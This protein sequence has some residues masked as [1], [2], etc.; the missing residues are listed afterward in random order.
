M[1]GSLRLIGMTETAP[2][3][4]LEHGGGFVVE[5][6]DQLKQYFQDQ[7]QEELAAF[8]AEPVVGSR[9]GR[10]FRAVSWYTPLQGSAV[11]LPEAKGEER[12][13]AIAHLRRMLVALEPHLDHPQAGPLLRRALLVPGEGSVMAVG[14]NAVLVNWALA[15]SAVLEDPD[16]LARHW[17]ATLGPYADFALTS[18][19]P[20]PGRSRAGAAAATAAGAAAGVAALSGAAAAAGPH[21]DQAMTAGPASGPDGGTMDTS[22]GYDPG[23]GGGYAA[24]TAVAATPW[25]QRGWIWALCVLL[26]LGAGIIIGILLWPWFERA[27][28]P[29]AETLRNLEAQRAVNQGLE[30]QIRRLREALQGDVC[31]QQDPLLAPTSEIPMFSVEGEEPGDAGDLQLPGTGS[32]DEAAPPV[33]APEDNATPAPG[34]GTTGMGDHGDAGGDAGGAAAP[35]GG[36]ASYGDGS[37]ENQDS[38]PETAPADLSTDAAPRLNDL[39]ARATVL[40]IAPSVMGPLAGSGMGTAFFVAP[41]TLVTNRHV[42]EGADPNRVYVTNSAL[43]GVQPARVVA[44]SSAADSDFALLSVHAPDPNAIQVLRATETIEPLDSVVAAGYPALLSEDDPQ[45]RALVLGGDPTA[46]PELVFTTGEVSATFSSSPPVV[47]HTAVL[48]QG[49]SGGPLVDRCGRVVG[50]NTL[51]KFDSQSYNQGNYSV[52][53]SQLLAFLRA[54]GVDM[55]VSS[56][57]CLPPGSQG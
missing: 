46:I 32:T 54:N 34:E 47:V 40:V 7:G 51:I 53:T 8:F 6:H 28:E 35:D 12:E 20:E 27:P 23:G 13:S 36:G 21:S 33:V 44:V 43:G 3:R 15:P 50:V 22:P 25:Y 37:T 29:S 39:L 16:A 30:D 45:Y 26:L 14:G 55:E 49:N 17:D 11:P 56:G 2:Y 38:A 57:R 31:S 1:E 42:V 52:A 9:G 18:L 19:N 4:A 10:G 48:S 41:D 5:Q 24:G